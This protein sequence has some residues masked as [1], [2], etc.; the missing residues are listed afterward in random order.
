MRSLSRG[1]IAAI[2]VCSFVLAIGILFIILWQKCI[3]PKCNQNGID[4]TNFSSIDASTTDFEF[5]D[6]TS[7]GCNGG[8]ITTALKG[9]TTDG[10]PWVAI[11]ST[12]WLQQKWYG[13]SVEANASDTPKAMYGDDYT[14]NCSYGKGGCGKS[15]RL[16]ANGSNGLGD[17][18]DGVSGV[19]VNAVVIDTCEQANQYGNNWQWCVPTYGGADNLEG[20]GGETAGPDCAVS[21]N[22]FKFKSNGSVTYKPSSKC[23]SLTNWKCTNY[24][25]YPTHFD[26]ASQ[27]LPQGDWVNDS[28]PAVIAKPITT[29][30]EIINILKSHCPDCPGYCSEVGSTGQNYNWITKL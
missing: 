4:L 14:S 8:D 25:G 11:A 3:L 30:T 1:E 27:S 10:Y 29:P 15:F 2:A 16:T 22:N 28:N 26:V 6:S 21:S 19:T 24:A 23:G 17:Q 7:C 5:G 18:G 20:A 13:N 9:V 12:D